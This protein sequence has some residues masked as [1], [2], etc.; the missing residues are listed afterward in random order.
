M[1]NNKAYG[2]TVYEYNDNTKKAI[3]KNGMT[4]LAGAL[5]A[6]NANSFDSIDTLFNNIDPKDGLDYKSILKGSTIENISNYLSKV[7]GR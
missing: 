1:I 3:I 5:L 7:A 2:V 4:M 6:K